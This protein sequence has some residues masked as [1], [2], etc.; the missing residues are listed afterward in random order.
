MQTCTK[1]PDKIRIS[2]FG[3]KNKLKIRICQ[4]GTDMQTLVS[5]YLG[6]DGV[7]QNLC[8]I[9][10]TIRNVFIAE[11]RSAVCIRRNCWRLIYVGISSATRL[12]SF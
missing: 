1:N 5:A 4:S 6:D 11:L 3:V 2:G 9:F 12:S 7:R 10:N 8:K